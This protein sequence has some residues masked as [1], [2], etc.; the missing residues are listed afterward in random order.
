MRERSLVVMI[1][2]FMKCNCLI[3]NPVYHVCDENGIS[4]L[5]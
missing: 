5:K 4:I 1:I 3:D 2:C